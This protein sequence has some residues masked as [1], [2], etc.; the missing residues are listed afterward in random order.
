MDHIRGLLTLHIATPVIIK[1]QNDG[2]YSWPVNVTQY[3]SDTSAI[4]KSRNMIHSLRV[5]ISFEKSDATFWWLCVV[6]CAWK[7]SVSWRMFLSASNL[8]WRFLARFSCVE[9]ALF[10]FVLL[11][12]SLFLILPS[13]DTFPFDSSSNNQKKLWWRSLRIVF[14]Q[15]GLSFGDMLS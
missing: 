9:M 12:I 11:D 1:S 5:G 8:F 15:W 10:L 14:G 6:M 3:R 2:P 13:Q 4:I 7:S